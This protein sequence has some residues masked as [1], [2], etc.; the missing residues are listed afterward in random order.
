MD[1][2]CLDLNMESW[3]VGELE[4]VCVRVIPF[5]ISNF[6]HEGVCG[7]GCGCGDGGEIITFVKNQMW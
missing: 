4:C 7:C 5:R 2:G 6:D 3:S 1:D